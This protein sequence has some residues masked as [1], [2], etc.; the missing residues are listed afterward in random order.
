MTLTPEKCTGELESLISAPGG[1]GGGRYSLH[2]ARDQ[3]GFVHVIKAAPPSPPSI[4]GSLLG[5][6]AYISVQQNDAVGLYSNPA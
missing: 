6:L 3:K 4:S 5:S 2:H 1:A